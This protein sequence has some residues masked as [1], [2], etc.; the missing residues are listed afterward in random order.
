MTLSESEKFEQGHR[1]NYADQLLDTLWS[2]CPADYRL[3]IIV[4]GA[5]DERIYPTL[6]ASENLT[7]S[8]YRMNV[9]EALKAAGPWLLQL[10]KGDWLSSWCINEGLEK[11]WFVIFASKG[12][13]FPHL[14]HH[15]RRFAIVQDEQGK[16][17]YFRYYDPRVL[18]AYLPTCNDSERLFVFGHIPCFWVKDAE[19]AQFTQFN[20]DGTEG[21]LEAFDIPIEWQL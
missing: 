11:N 2:Q 21:S 16:H 10:H 14:L 1:Q 13:T 4:D 15:F 3:Y 18:A 6:A 12:K 19:S 5:Q 20:S 8:L 7:R 9:D 17:L